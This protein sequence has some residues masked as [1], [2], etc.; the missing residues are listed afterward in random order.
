MAKSPKSRTEVVVEQNEK[1]QVV[2]VEPS[3]S[4]PG[5][6]EKVT[7]KKVDDS[8]VFLYKCSCGNVHFRHAGYV[9]LMLPFIEPGKKEV[10][11]DAKSVM[12]CTKCKKPFAWISGQAYD[13][14]DRIDMKA[15]EKTEKVAHK[16]TG[17]GGQC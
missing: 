1:I 13:L 8:Q 2:V 14:S 6:A 9:E 17:P 11:L 15:W 16:T 4:A 10:C 3:P 5:F 12:V 7:P